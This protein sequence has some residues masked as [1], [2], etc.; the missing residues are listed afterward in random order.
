[1]KKFT[2]QNFEVFIE[3]LNSDDMPM[4]S[5]QE[6]ATSLLAKFKAWLEKP[7]KPEEVIMLPVHVNGTE[8]RNS[9]G[10]LVANC[11]SHLVALAVSEVM[12]SSYLPP[13]PDDVELLGED[14]ED[15]GDFE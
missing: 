12:N 6:L 13:D 7:Y 9:A 4:L 8:I 14:D 15:D 1:M 11:A 2:E 10:M 5:E 3:T